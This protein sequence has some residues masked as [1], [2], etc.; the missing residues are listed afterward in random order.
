MDRRTFLTGAAA[1]AAAGLVLNACGGDDGA[2][3]ATAT[4]SGD[5]PGASG[6]STNRS[7]KL[8]FIALTDCASILMAQEL[9]YFAERDLQVTIEKQASWPATRDNL[10]TNQIDGCH[11]LYTLPLSVA[12]GLGGDGRRDIFVAMMLNNNG[13]AITLN[14]NLAEAGY[15]DLEAAKEALLKGGPPALAM[16]FPGGTHDLWLRYWLKAAKVDFGEVS[17]QAVPPAQM[18]QNMGT[19]NVQGYCVGE[20]WGAVAVRQDIGFTH[21]ATQD[22]WLNHPEKAFLVTRKFKEERP[23]VVRDCMAA[24][25]KASKWLDDFTNRNEAAEVIGQEK[26]I[27]APAAEIAGRLNGIYDLGL[28]LGEK[29]YEGEQMR[30]F[31]DGA[32]N[33]PRKSH[34]IWAMAQ[35]QRFGLLEEAPPY[36]ELADELIL[37]DLYAEVAAAEGI[38]IPDDDMQPF[39]VVLDDVTFDPSN[40]AEEV[41]RA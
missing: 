9:G 41:A 20:P 13:Q 18:V 5:A 34:Y 14:K 19:N 7:V 40:P 23:D 35:Y 31:R 21:L 39:D 37:T 36:Q 24:I 33:F 25:L 16:T 29:D 4:T 28:D 32:T 22:L 8:G 38:D 3:E 10:L 26:Y 15:A 2:A 27:N 17:I 11:G 1:T 30:F 12:T 6:S